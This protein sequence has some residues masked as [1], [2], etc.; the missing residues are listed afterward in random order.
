MEWTEVVYLLGLLAAM[1]IRTVYGLR[2]GRRGGDPSIRETL[3][4]GFFMALWGVGLLLPLI[5]IFGPW[6]SFADYELPLWSGW[7]G[8]LLFAGGIL[9]LWRSHADLDVSFSPNL[10]LMEDHELVTVG[11]YEQIRHPMYAAHIL[12]GVSQ[13]LLIPNWLAGPLALVAAVGIYLN[14]V[15]REEEMMLHRF[16]EAYRRYQKRTSRLLPRIGAAE[17]DQRR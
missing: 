7:L 17:G 12:W 3:A 16:G 9:L 11:V 6:L 14:R 1:V 8:T 4:A 2:Y 13:P 15:D 10:E 5:Q